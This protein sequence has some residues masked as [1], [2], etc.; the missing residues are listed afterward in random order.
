MKWLESLA[1]IKNIL[2]NRTRRLAL[3]GLPFKCPHAA[4]EEAETV[5]S[6]EEQIQ[7]FIDL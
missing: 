1:E 3:E 6:I 7:Q 4:G 5:K 2:Q